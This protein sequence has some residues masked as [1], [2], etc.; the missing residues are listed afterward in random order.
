M[1]QRCL[2]LALRI[3][4][5]GCIGC[6]LGSN[7]LEGAP[8]PAAGLNGQNC[9][10][11]IIDPTIGY[12]GGGTVYTY[13]PVTTYN[14]PSG[15]IFQQG[16][17]CQAGYTLTSTRDSCTLPAN[18]SDP[19]KNIGDL[20]FCP[21]CLKEQ[22]HAGTNPIN[23]G[24]GGKH[25]REVDYTGIGAYPLN[26]ERNYDSGGTTP[27]V[28]EATVWGSQWRST[29]NRSNAINTNNVITTAAV[30][31]PDGKSYYYN[32]SGTSFVGDADVVGSL[33]QL[34]APVVPPATVGAAAGWRYTNENDEVET[35]DVAGKL[36]SLT[37]K[38]GLVQT[39][40]YSDSTAVVPNGGYTPQSVIRLPACVLSATTT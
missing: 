37:N 16:G 40:N 1:C 22:T 39:L 24:T 29:Y 32:L 28:V 11:T 18:A 6:G 36:I 5:F 7:I 30:K 17:V 20:A 27:T 2:Q 38:A 35:Y 26:L 13:N 23:S 34:F 15:S 19:T 8:N 21:D 4:G 3:S 14:S 10:W 33:V 25:Q 31:P 9:L 12:G